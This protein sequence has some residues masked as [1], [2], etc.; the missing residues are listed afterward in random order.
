M[1]QNC[2]VCVE[3]IKHPIRKLLGH[4]FPCHVWVIFQRCVY[5]LQLHLR[6]GRTLVLFGCLD[7]LAKSMIG[8]SRAPHSNLGMAFSAVLVRFLDGYRRIAMWAHYAS[9]LPEADESTL[10]VCSQ[11]EPILSS[12]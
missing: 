7:Y 11:L 4:I 1:H 8:L 2:P 10:P 5:T 6:H 3:V 12:S 9:I